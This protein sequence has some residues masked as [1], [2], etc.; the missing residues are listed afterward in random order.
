MP[1][2][3]T[4]LT[5]CAGEHYVAYKLSC[6]GIIAAMTREGSPSVDIMASTID[7]SKTLAIQVK[8]A[9]WASRTRGRG[10]NKVL[11]HLQFPLGYNSATHKSDNLY[12]AFVDLNSI[13]W[14]EKEPDVYIIPSKFVFDYCKSWVNNVK[15]VR[16]HIEIEEMQPYK[17]NWDI[18]VKALHK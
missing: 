10:K 18:L 15:W 6:N 14:D 13:T 17:N 4:K 7:G 16:F 9:D 3:N 11:D 2:Q 5:A 12:F 1:K 8:T